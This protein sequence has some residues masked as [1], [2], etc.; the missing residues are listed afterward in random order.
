M[1]TQ[2]QL[3]PEESA[4][5][6]ENQGFWDGVLVGVRIASETAKS[7]YLAELIAAHQPAPPK[8]VHD[9]PQP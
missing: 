6:S 4:K 5:L 1:Q 7:R 3:T 8:E 2:I 9:V